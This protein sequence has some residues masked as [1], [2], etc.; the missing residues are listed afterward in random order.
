M[1]LTTAENGAVTLG[2]DRYAVC[3]EVACELEALAYVLPTVTSNA[4]EGALRVGFVV[5]GIAGRCTELASVL[6]A[7][8]DDKDE[9]T[10][11]LKRRV[12]VTPMKSA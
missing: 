5:R 12:L 6:M 2:K 10:S 3:V 9:T 4:D 7:A 11:D 8:L 1:S